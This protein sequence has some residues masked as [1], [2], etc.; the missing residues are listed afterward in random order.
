MLQA[1]ACF[2]WSSFL[3]R[4]TRVRQRWQD[5]SAGEGRH[6]ARFLTGATTCAGGSLPGGVADVFGASISGSDPSAYHHWTPTTCRAGPSNTRTGRMGFEDARSARLAEAVVSC[7]TRGVCHPTPGRRRH[8]EVCIVLIGELVVFCSS[9]HRPCWH[10]TRLLM[11]LLLQRLA[12][13][14]MGQQ[15]TSCWLDQL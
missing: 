11:I 10:A 8:V 3:P 5:R 12:M 4:W 15:K 2:A 7:N 6:K 14:P 1:R 9:P 13:C